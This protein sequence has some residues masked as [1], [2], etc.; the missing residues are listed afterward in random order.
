MPARIVIA[1]DDAEFVEDTVT[2]LWDAGYDVVAFADSMS[3]L[4]AGGCAARRGADYARAIYGGTAERHL[5]REDGADE[6]PGD[7]GALR[8]T[9]GDTGAYRGVRRV[10]ADAYCRY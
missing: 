1:H 2:A 10:S 9:A 6:A 8:R 5:T 7:Q 4:D 3:A